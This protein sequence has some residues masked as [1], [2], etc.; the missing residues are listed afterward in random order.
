MIVHKGLKCNK[1]AARAAAGGAFTIVV[2]TALR[3]HLETALEM[4]VQLWV[5]DVD[6]EPAPGR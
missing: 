6:S 2:W 4:L 1:N 5:T 3:R